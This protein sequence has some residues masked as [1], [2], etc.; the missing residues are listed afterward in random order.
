MVTIEPN[1]E[2]GVKFDGEINCAELL[3][4]SVSPSKGWIVIQVKLNL[5]ISGHTCILMGVWMPPP[6]PLGLYTTHL[7][8]SVYRI[9]GLVT[10][11]HKSIAFTYTRTPY[12]LY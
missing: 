7:A 8:L 1:S 3:F 12:N 5:K 9:A 6:N 2:Q 10:Q 4:R 11:L